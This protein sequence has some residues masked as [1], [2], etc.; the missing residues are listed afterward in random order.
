MKN[1]FYA[2]CCFSGY[3]FFQLLGIVIK[4]FP[5]S[6]TGAVA[7]SIL[8]LLIILGL[9]FNNWLG[10]WYKSSGNLSK[11]QNVVGFAPVYLFGTVAIFALIVGFM[12]GG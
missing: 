4:G 10:L 8:G 9:G 6:R 2:G 11:N 1:L 5:G 12:V 3:S 7:L